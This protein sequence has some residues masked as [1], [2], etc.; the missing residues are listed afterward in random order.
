[1]NNEDLKN[2]SDEELLTLAGP[3]ILGQTINGR[4]YANSL[5]QDGNGSLTPESERALAAKLEL[6][7]R[8]TG[9]A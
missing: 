1:M 5:V 3:A 7:R 8:N 6:R 9:K 2:K 4:H